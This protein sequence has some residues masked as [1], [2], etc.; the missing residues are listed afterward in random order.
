MIF[1][2]VGLELCQEGG[3]R[4]PQTDTQS[5]PANDGTNLGPVSGNIHS[6]PRQP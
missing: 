2:G 3:G 6:S 4:V 1:H 5:A